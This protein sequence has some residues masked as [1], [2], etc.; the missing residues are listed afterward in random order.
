MASG[1][2]SI[3]ES[4]VERNCVMIASVSTTLFFSG[5]EARGALEIKAE[6]S[7]TEEVGA[8]ETGVEE[9]GTEGVASEEVGT[10]EVG[11]EGVTSE[12]DSVEEV[13]VE[14]FAS[15][16]VGSVEESADVEALDEGS[17]ECSAGREEI[18]L[19]G[20]SSAAGRF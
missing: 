17:E 10:E 19:V 2:K 6:K 3:E 20:G 4:W 12:E 14:E 16:E 9:T 1:V 7:E 11:R 13:G 15:E 18:S 5:A 8:E